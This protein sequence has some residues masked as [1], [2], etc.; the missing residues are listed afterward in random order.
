MSSTLTNIEWFRLENVLGM[1]LFLKEKCQFLRT[2]Q[3]TM[4]NHYP[5]RMIGRSALYVV[6]Y[7]SYRGVGGIEADPPNWKMA[8]VLNAPIFW[9]KKSVTE[10]ASIWKFWI[11]IYFMK[12]RHTRSQ[13]HKKNCPISQVEGSVPAPLTSPVIWIVRADRLILP[14]NFAVT[15]FVR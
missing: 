6:K 10:M 14:K 13:G 9:K 4:Y 7:P 12:N 11:P 8:L 3:L 15:C 2:K 1:L 5:K